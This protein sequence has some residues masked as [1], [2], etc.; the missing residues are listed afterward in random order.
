MTNTIG[1]APGLGC[2]ENSSSARAKG[3]M[4]SVVPRAWQ[5]TLTQ[6]S[7][8]SF[9]SFVAFVSPSWSK[10]ICRLSN[11]Q[12]LNRSFGVR[13][14]R[15][16]MSAARAASIG[17]PPIDP[18]RSKR[19]ITSRGN[20]FTASGLGGAMAMAKACLRSGSPGAGGCC[21]PAAAMSPPQ[22]GITITN[23]VFCHFSRLMGSS[24]TCVTPAPACT[25]VTGCVGDITCTCSLYADRAV[26]ITESTL[27]RGVLGGMH[28]VGRR[29][30]ARNTYAPFSKSSGVKYVACTCTVSPAGTPG[31][32][33]AK[34]SGCAGNGAAV[35]RP[36]RVPFMFLVSLLGIT[37]LAKRLL[38]ICAE[39]PVTVVCSVT[40][41]AKVMLP[42]L[43]SFLAD[44]RSDPGTTQVVFTVTNAVDRWHSTWKS[45]FWSCAGVN[46]VSASP[47]ALVAYKPGHAGR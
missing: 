23:S 31:M 40:G 29:V 18:E 14:F 13:S 42:F 33:M 22:T 37:P 45:I 38:D 16:A 41:M 5:L 36:K 4:M 2:A 17:P 35:F 47:A 32:E 1:T 21:T 7:A 12:M 28:P 27:V 26:A 30:G 6:R 9:A 10:K 43:P 20:G 15:P 19:K 44:F 11:A 25:R 8:A 39:T 46:T 24:C 34:S 3:V